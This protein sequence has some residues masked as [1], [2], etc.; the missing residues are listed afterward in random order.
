M[1]RV[2][3]G[4]EFD[5]ELEEVFL[6]IPCTFD[7][8]GSLRL[9]TDDGASAMSIWP[10]GPALEWYLDGGSTTPATEEIDHDECIRQAREMADYFGSIHDCP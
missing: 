3:D 6:E 4:V 10:V 8:D 7:E 9:A 5:G 2:H 1:E